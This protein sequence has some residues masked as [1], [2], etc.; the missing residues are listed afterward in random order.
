LSN[1]ESLALDRDQTDSKSEYLTTSALINH[2]S[3]SECIAQAAC[4]AVEANGI[5][6]ALVSFSQV[7]K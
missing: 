4:G 6:Q 5:V 2:L 3:K 7:V 1:H